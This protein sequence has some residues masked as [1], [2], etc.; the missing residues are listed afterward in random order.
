MIPWFYMMDW[1]MEP[2]K[3]KGTVSEIGGKRDVNGALR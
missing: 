1:E 2:T 3:Y